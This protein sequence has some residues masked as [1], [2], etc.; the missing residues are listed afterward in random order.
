MTTRIATNIL[1]RCNCK[2]SLR[3][4]CKYSFPYGR[5]YYFTLRQILFC[6]MLQI[7]FSITASCFLCGIRCRAW[8]DLWLLWLQNTSVVTI[9]QIWKTKRKEIKLCFK[10]WFFYIWYKSTQLW[11]LMRRAMFW[12]K[13]R[14]ELFVSNNRFLK[15]ENFLS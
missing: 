13:S 6:I 15:Q 3:Y 7:F 1:F 9:N 5:K 11:R 8:N 2:Y 12:K 4:S 10:W 14:Q